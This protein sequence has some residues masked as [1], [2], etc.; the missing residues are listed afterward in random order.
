[1]ILIPPVPEIKRTSSL[2][3]SVRLVKLL[4]DSTLVVS[5]L[6]KGHS[7]R[8]VVFNLQPLLPPML[9]LPNPP[10]NNNNIQR[11]QIKDSITGTSLDLPFGIHLDLTVLSHLR[12]GLLLLLILL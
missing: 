7:L 6:F 10:G 9:L 4:M 11:I 1:M 8:S 12:I 3:I 5:L 2:L